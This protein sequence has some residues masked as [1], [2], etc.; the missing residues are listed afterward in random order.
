MAN[1]ARI[2]GTLAALGVLLA[3]VGSAPAARSLVPPRITAAQ[4]SG[5]SS[6][7][8]QRFVIDLLIDN[9]NS[10]PLAIKEIRFTMRIA[11]QGVLTG[12]YSTPVIVE[13]LDRRTVQVDVD[14]AALSSFSQLRANAGPDNTVGYEIYG[15]VTLDRAFKNTLPFNADGSVPLGNGQR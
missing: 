2:L 5:Q 15:N 10:D 3:P 1:Y 6:A 8:S 9:Q 12:R 4:L 7:G 14:G 13:A 11:G